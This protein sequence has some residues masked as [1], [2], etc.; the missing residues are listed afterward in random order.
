MSIEPQCYYCNEVTKY[1]CT[2]KES[3]DCIAKKKK[4]DFPNE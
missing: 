1:R 3:K 4:E 2:E